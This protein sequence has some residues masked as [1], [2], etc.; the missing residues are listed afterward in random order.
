MLD[1]DY[2]TEESIPVYIDPAKDCKAWLKRKGKSLSTPELIVEASKKF[3]LSRKEVE[4]I[5][6]GGNN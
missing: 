4:S 1:I 3:E 5:R 6:V 2:F